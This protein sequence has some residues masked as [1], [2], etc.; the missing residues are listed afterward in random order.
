[1]NSRLNGFALKI[2]SNFCCWEIHLQVI[3][4]QAAV[5]RCNAHVD[6]KDESFPPYPAV[7]NDNGLHLHVERVGQ[8]LLG[9]G[10]VHAAKKV[11]AGEDFAFY[12]EVIPGVMFGI[13]IRNEKV[14]SIHSPH[15][16]FFFLDEEVLP[17]GA[18]MHAAVAELYF[19]N[20]NAK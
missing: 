15:S 5:H 1:M 4:G 16:P 10:N 8:L 7:V 14:G 18:A 20:Y 9:P 12:Q 11:M 2:L 3:E 17:I 13:G 6:F 19:N